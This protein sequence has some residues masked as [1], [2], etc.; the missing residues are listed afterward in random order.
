M[1][2]RCGQVIG[3]DILEEA[4]VDARNN[5]LTNDITNC[6]FFVGSAED[7]LPNL[8]KRVAFSEA[9]VVID[10]PR[11]GLGPKAIQAIR[12][13]ETVTKVIYVASDPA[14]VMKNFADLARPPSNTFKGDPFVPVKVAPVDMFPHTNNFCVAILFMRVKMSDL[15]NPESISVDS[16]NS[17]QSRQGPSSSRGGRGGGSFTANRPPPKKG[18]E[19]PS[20]NQPPPDLSWKPV[21]KVSQPPPSQQQPPPQQES[22]E[23]L[24]ADQVTWLN[25]MTQVYGNQFERAQWIETFKQ[26]NKEASDSYYASIGQQQQQVMQQPPPPPMQQQQQYSSA[27]QPQQ[28]PGQW[29]GGAHNPSQFNPV[30]PPGPVPPPPADASKPPPA[31]NTSVMGPAGGAEQAAWAEYAKQ[32]ANYWST[33]A[34]PRPAATAAVTMGTAISA[35]SQPPPPPPPLPA[36]PPAS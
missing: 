28:W 2:S 1:C 20:Y 21:N 33:V 27:A 31:T 25:Q 29:A 5:A 34:G 36:E 3:L 11:A 18:P 7:A 17:Q 13:N 32:M 8:W 24:S 12:K 30:P 16:Y 15:V 35:M 10:P 6:E 23:M 9:I 26:Q 19:A 14:S 22:L 4:I